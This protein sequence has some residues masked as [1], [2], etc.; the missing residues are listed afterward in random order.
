MNFERLNHWLTLVANVGVV[1]GIIFL[2]YEIRLTRDALVGATYQQRT[3]AVENWDYNI[4]D[5]TYVSQAIRNYE[6]ALAQ[7]DDFESL[8]DDDKFRLTSITVATFN[9]LDNFFYQ[10]ELGLVSEEMYEHAFH[11]EMTVQV[12]RFVA[13]NLFDH[14]YIKLALRPSF[15]EEIE[16]YVDADLVI[17]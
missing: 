13:L 3:T 8:S 2:A 4:A 14:P 9:R 12:P 1:A 10:Y 17:F 5:S 16:K 6:Q 15:R 7:G 11:A